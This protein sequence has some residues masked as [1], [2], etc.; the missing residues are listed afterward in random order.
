MWIGE[1]SL[2]SNQAVVLE[3]ESNG[4]IHFPSLG[5]AAACRVFCRLPPGAPNHIE[6]CK[7]R[8]PSRWAVA[9]PGSTL[10]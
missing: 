9:E 10:V 6:R 8:C 5:A 2:H 3:I 1:G 4:L 7:Q